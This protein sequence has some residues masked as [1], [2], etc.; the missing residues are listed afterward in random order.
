[1]GL[2]SPNHSKTLA[3][4]EDTTFT[5]AAIVPITGN[6]DNVLDI[7]ETVSATEVNV[8]FDL[9]SASRVTPVR[10]V[11]PWI[12]IQVGGRKAKNVGAVAGITKDPGPD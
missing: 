1:V 6:E 8:P 5:P 3:A 2:E 12:L 4:A 10:F 11:G 7:L 9:A